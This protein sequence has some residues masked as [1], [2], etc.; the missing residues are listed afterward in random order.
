MVHISP[1]HIGLNIHWSC[2][3]TRLGKIIMAATHTT[4]T[5]CGKIINEC[6]GKYF[7]IQLRYSLS[8]ARAV[9]LNPVNEILCLLSA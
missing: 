5:T 3:Y 7:K 2:Q 6:Q 1:R 4:L 8:R 9:T